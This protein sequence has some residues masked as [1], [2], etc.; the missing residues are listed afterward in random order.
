MVCKLR[1]LENIIGAARVNL[2]VLVSLDRLGNSIDDVR[3]K[4]TVDPC[5]F[6]HLRDHPEIDLLDRQPVHIRIQQDIELK[7]RLI[8]ELHIHV[9]DMV[10]DDIP[11]DHDH[12]HDLIRGK[13]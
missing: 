10:L 11:L 12:D 2:E 6:L 1:V 4:L 5:L 7:E 9:Q 3:D 13:P 8:V